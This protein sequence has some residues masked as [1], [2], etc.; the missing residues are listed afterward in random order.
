MTSKQCTLCEGKADLFYSKSKIYFICRTCKGIHLDEK[1]YL[2]EKLEKIRYETH[3]NDVNDEGY[4]N[5]VSP[6]TNAILEKYNQN[7]NGLDFGAGT[8]PVIKK[9]LNENKIEINLYDPYFHPDKKVLNQKYDFISCCE[10]IEHFYNP[11]KEFNTLSNILKDNGSLFIMTDIYN[12]EI[13]FDKWYYKNDPTHVFFYQERTFETIAEKF[14]FSDFK[15]ENR[16]IEF[17]K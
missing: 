17:K 1:F 12:P 14:N 6:I 13:N 9:I 4:Q 8:G 2:D 16:L 7:H 5:F 15:I 11:S 10:V 3:N